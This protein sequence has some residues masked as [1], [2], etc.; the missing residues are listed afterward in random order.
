M[1]ADEF[2]AQAVPQG[3]KP[4]TVLLVEDEPALIAA[5]SSL[6]RKRGFRVLSAASGEAARAMLEGGMRVDILFSDVNLGGLIDGL[7]L[8]AWARLNCPGI[9]ILLTS[10]SL[11][12]RALDRG[13]VDAPL[14]KKPYSGPELVEQLR[15]LIQTFARPARPAASDSL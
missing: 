7:D 8:A 4:V 6:L 14:V 1:H 12:P 13:L 2:R 11:S 15:A 10:G 3:G 9:R 5:V